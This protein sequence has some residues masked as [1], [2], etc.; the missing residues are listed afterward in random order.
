MDVLVEEQT[1]GKTIKR[2][3]MNSKSSM[4]S[5]HYREYRKTHTIKFSIIMRNDYI[6]KTTRNIKQ[7][8]AKTAL[9]MSKNEKCLYMLFRDRF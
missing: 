8:F 4:R 7:I 3:F 2:I 1:S 9:F 6:K 5:T